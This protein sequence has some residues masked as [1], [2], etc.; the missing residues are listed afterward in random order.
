MS[1][2][3]IAALLLATFGGLIGIFRSDRRRRE[4]RNARLRMQRP[5]S[6]QA[7]TEELSRSARVQVSTVEIVRREFARCSGIVN[8]EQIQ[9]TDSL[10]DLRPFGFDDIGAVEFTMQIEE[11]LSINVPSRAW[12]K[13]KTVRDLILLVEEHRSRTGPTSRTRHPNA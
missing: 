10:R 11:A 8:H 6:D 4:R 3:L 5:V 2:W 13:P 12:S 7:I 1:H 9:L